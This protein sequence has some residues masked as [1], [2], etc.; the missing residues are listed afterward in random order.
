MFTKKPNLEQ[1]KNCMPAV[2]H[3]FQNE[4][5]PEFIHLSTEDNKKEIKI[6]C[7]NANERFMDRDTIFQIFSQ[8]LDKIHEGNTVFF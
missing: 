4:H 8:N 7:G 3:V 1:F 5:A 2:I 6:I